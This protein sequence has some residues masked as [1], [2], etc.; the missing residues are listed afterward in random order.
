VGEKVHED[1]ENAKEVH[2]AVYLVS[3]VLIVGWSILPRAVWTR[4]H[5]AVGIATAGH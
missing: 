4:T 2:P 5:D 3:L 1:F